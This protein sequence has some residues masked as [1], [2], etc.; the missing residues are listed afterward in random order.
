MENCEITQDNSIM[1][2]EGELSDEEEL[3]DEKRNGNG[4]YFAHAK[5]FQS[6]GRGR[7]KS[8]QNSTSRFP[9]SPRQ[10]YRDGTNNRTE[11][12]FGPTN[13]YRSPPGPQ[14]TLRSYTP[15]RSAWATPPQ[16]PY[17]LNM[18]FQYDQQDYPRPQAVPDYRRHKVRSPAQCIL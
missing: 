3:C 14:P 18:I 16:Q 15:P 7:N 5:R 10:S 9:Y 11:D 13:L 2:E 17:I 6:W 8:V 4:N 12:G 1:K